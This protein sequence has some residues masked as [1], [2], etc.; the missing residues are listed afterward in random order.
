[1]HNIDWLRLFTFVFTK[2]KIL[3]SNLLV[4]SIVTTGKKVKAYIYCTVFE[5]KSNKQNVSIRQTL[6]CDLYFESNP[7]TSERKKA[8]MIPY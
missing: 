1:M 7:T 6:L 4:F 5:S 8:H 3:K 2:Q